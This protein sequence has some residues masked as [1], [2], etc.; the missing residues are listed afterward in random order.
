LRNSDWRG[1]GIDGTAFAGADLSLA[2]LDAQHGPRLVDADLSHASL[3]RGLGRPPA[4]APRYRP[5]WRELPM[6][7]VNAVAFSP[8]GKR[9]ASGGNDGTLRLWD[10]ASG[11]ELRRIEGHGGRL[12]SVAFS[13]NGTLAAAGASI[14]IFDADS[15]RA[16]PGNDT[17]WRCQIRMA[18]D[19]V[20]LYPDG[21]HAGSGEALEWLEYEELPRETLDSALADPLPTLHRATD[22][23][24]LSVEYDTVV[25][26]PTKSSRPARTAAQA[27]NHRRARMPT[28]G[29]RYGRSGDDHTAAPFDR[30]RDDRAGSAVAD[31]QTANTV[32]TTADANR[33]INASADPQRA[34][35][36]QALVAHMSRLTGCGP[37]MRVS[38][39]RLQTPRWLGKQSCFHGPRR[40]LD[41]GS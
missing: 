6:G 28:P 19:A 34:Q 27:L 1:G 41:H 35:E 12:L 16:G 38:S 21:R 29:P 4:P 32:A 23:P 20:A 3:V 5:Q 22:L 9:L 10:A 36:C 14:S 40:P 26:A 33:H 24:W 25:V 31:T 8:D 30:P 2:R 39:R 37:V 17:A 11:R 18:G 7:D 13:R 15:S